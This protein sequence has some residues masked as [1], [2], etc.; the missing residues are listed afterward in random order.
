[1]DTLVILDFGSQFSQLIARRVREAR[2]YCEL[3][4]CDAPAEKV[5][6]LKPKAIILS[7]GPNSVYDPGAPQLPGY[8]LQSGLP[9]LGVCYGMQ[10]L[11]QA[12][13]GHVHPS[14]QREYGRAQLLITNNQSPLLAGIPTASQVWMSHGDKVDQLPSGFL[15]TA[16]SDNCP[17]AAMEDPA[18]KL[19]AIQFHPEVNHTEHGRQI[20]QQFIAAA[21]IKA[22]WTPGSVVEEAVAKIRA[23]VK[24]APVVA[25]VSGGVDSSVA[26]ALVHRA[27]G[28]QLTCIFVNTGLLRAGEPEAVAETFGQMLHAKLVAVNATEEF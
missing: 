2:V 11:A 27:V 14:T 10:L 24:E 17:I 18:R 28:D 13:G 7:G 15:T 6:A 25:A 22:E 26:A 3:F 20:L 4:P 1:M 21:G 5:L 16:A 23:Q 12:L 9:V 8:V 19:F